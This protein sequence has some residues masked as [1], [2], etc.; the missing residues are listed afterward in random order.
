MT[1]SPSVPFH[2]GEQ[3]ALEDMRVTVTKVNDRGRAMSA[4]FRF[5][6][7]L[8]D[9]KWLWMAFNRSVLESWSPPAIG[10]RTTLPPLL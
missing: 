7:P 5:A 10:E 9:P 4:E 6:S 1:R 2:V 8:E 3:V